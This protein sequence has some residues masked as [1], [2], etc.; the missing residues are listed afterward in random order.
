MNIRRIDHYL[1][2]PTTG[3][4]R[5]FIAD[6]SLIVCARLI[7]ILKD[8]DGIA[9]VGQAQNANDAVQMVMAVRP[10]VAIVD[11]QMPGGGG[12][13]VLRQIKATMPSTIV[14]MVTNHMFPQYR[15]Q[16]VNDGAEYFFD[17]AT[18]IDQVVEVLSLITQRVS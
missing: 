16:S 14:I 2:P 11:I 9:I 12:F 6:D 13:H 3:M 5:V 1:L 17:K 8:M 7:A 4:V 10:D 15:Q 18:E